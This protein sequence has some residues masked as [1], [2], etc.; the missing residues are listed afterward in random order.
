[1]RLASQDAVCFSSGRRRAI[2][3]A[4]CSPMSTCTRGARYTGGAPMLVKSG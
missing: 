4:S 2:E 3:R 1:V